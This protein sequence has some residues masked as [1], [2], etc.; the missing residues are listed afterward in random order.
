MHMLTIVLLVWFVLLL[1]R[2]KVL[3]LVLR[4]PQRPYYCFA[5][6]SGSLPF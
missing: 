6:L 2:V 4:V 3:R 5:N 1:R